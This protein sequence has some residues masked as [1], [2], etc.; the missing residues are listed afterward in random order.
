MGKGSKRR[1]KLITQEQFEDNWDK[2]FGRKI[3]PNHGKT[4]RHTDRTKVIPRK[5]KYNRAD[6]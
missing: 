2:I 5:Q 1:P 3:T 4:Q 6:R